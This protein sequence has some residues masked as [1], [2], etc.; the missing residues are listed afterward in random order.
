M[1]RHAP[2]P[3]K[4]ATRGVARPPASQLDALLTIGN[5][6]SSEQKQQEAQRGRAAPRPPRRPHEEV[7]GSEV[8]RSSTGAGSS[9]S[10]TLAPTRSR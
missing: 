8:Y 6:A 1:R 9:S 5:V 3:E 4:M 2:P 7:R 10:A